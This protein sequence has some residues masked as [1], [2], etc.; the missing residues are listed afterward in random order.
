MVIT[1]GPKPTI[2]VTK[3]FKRKVNVLPIESQVLGVLSKKL[4][5]QRKT[6]DLNCSKMTLLMKL[7]VDTT[8]AGDAFC[9][10]FLARLYNSTLTR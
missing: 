2:L 1:S 6:L 9:G 3:S 10:G 5:V 4:F 8:G 7:I